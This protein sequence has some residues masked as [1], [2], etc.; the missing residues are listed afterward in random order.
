VALVVFTGGARS[1]KSTAAAELA[2]LRALDGADV[3]VAVFGRESV[4]PE[5]ARRIE[6]HRDARP[7]EWATLEVAATDELIVRV[8][9]ASLL[10][11][12]CMGTLLGLAM[13]EAFSEVTTGSELSGAE[14]DDLPVGFEAALSRRYEPLVSWLKTRTGDTIVVTNEVGDGVVPLWASGRL[15]RDELGRINRSLISSADSAYLCVSGR[16]ID[17]SALPV[18]AHWPED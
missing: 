9:D 14:S 10:V 17:L 16:L 8:A 13:E 12:D 2:G 4:D 15:F 6:L 7:A 5:F 3:T 18:V 11:V 1:G